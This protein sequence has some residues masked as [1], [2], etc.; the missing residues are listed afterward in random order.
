MRK[1]NF[2]QHRYKCCIDEPN[3]KNSG[4]THQPDEPEI[5]MH[6]ACGVPLSRFS[7][8]VSSGSPSQSGSG[9]DTCSP[10]GSAGA[11]RS[12]PPWRAPPGGRRRP[13]PAPRTLRPARRSRRFQ[14]PSD[15][16]KSH[17][18]P[19]FR[20]QF[21]YY[22]GNQTYKMSCRTWSGIQSC[23]GFPLSC[24]LGYSRE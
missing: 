10:L 22:S 19:V 23:S 18:R 5:M 7:P 2:N 6:S 13:R 16:P 1:R 12:V 14:G 21:T 4:G 15:A 3:W 20:G 11:R 9:R 8:P 17:P 24:P